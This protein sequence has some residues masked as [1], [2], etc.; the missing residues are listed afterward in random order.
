MWSEFSEGIVALFSQAAS[1]VTNLWQGVAT[2][3][4]ESLLDASAQGGV[5]GKAASLVLGTDMSKEQAVAEKSR[6]DNIAA[7]QARFTQ[8][9]GFIEQ[10]KANGGSLQLGSETFT[11]AD[12]ER[13]RDEAAKQVKDNQGTIVNVTK[14]AKAVAADLIGGIAHDFKAGLEQANRDAQA[15]SQQAWS[16]FVKTQPAAPA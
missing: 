8:F 9:N 12:L 16:G 6:L 11:T 2:S 15:Q 10:A 13:T 3:I 7:G 14:D 4:A 5:L 1:A